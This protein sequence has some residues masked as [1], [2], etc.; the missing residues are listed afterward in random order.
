MNGDLISRAALVKAL[1]AERDK[2]PPE[3]NGE[4]QRY[5][6]AIRGGIRKALREIEMAPAVDAE[7]VVHGRWIER[8]FLLGTTHVCS[9]CG[10]YYGMPHGVFKFCPNCGAKMDKEEI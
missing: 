10:D 2:H 4:H 1:I 9:E 3:V 7:P 5:N 8:P 6:Q